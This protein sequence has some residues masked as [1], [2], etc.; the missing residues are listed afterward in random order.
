M[1]LFNIETSDYTPSPSIPKQSNFNIE[2]ENYTP[3]PS[4]FESRPSFETDFNIELADYTPPSS[5]PTGSIGGWLNTVSNL[6]PSVQKG[7]SSFFGGKDSVGSP[8]SQSTQSEG[9]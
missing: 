1:A 3:S 9:S 5:Q 2:L 8:L 7:L 4:S 6:L